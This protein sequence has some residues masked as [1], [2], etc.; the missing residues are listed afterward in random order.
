MIEYF[1]LMSRAVILYFLIILFLRIMG[2][3]EVGELSV[4]DLVLYFVMS[5]L[6]TLSLENV[7]ESIWKSVVPIIT[8]TLMQLVLSWIILKRK[9]VRD[10]V[11]GSPV[12]IIK[13]G[14]INQAEMKRQRYSIDDLMYQLR[15][16]NIGSV[17]EV[18]FALLENAGVLTVLK[19]GQCTLNYPHPL[20]S[21]GEVK[22]NI[23]IDA[24]VN[25][26]WLMNK[27]KQKGV[28]RISDVFLCLWEK[29][30]LLVIMKDGK[31]NAK[32]MKNSSDKG[33]N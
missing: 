13:H 19:V 28:E 23:L 27:L 11:E 7:E 12:I 4:F 29:T 31:V 17:S 15:E 10:F 1:N 5:E 8:L 22:D 14:I 32:Q 30:G 26:K 20:I 33:T 9:N 16:K 21:D 3:R 18:E 6:V 2:K 25:R 24:G